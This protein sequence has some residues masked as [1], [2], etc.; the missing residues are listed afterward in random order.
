MRDCPYVQARDKALSLG[1]KVIIS[2]RATFNG[3]AL[4]LAGFDPMEVVDMTFCAGLSSH[5]KRNVTLGT[6]FGGL[7]RAIYRVRE[8]EAK[9][10]EASDTDDSSDIDLNSTFHREL[11]DVPDTVSEDIF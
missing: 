5:Q 4:L 11:E 6:D 2:P 10:I 8:D 1:F 9:H 7:N 3:I